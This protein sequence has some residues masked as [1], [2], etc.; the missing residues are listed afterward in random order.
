METAD[1]ESSK[2][3]TI[4]RIAAPHFVAGAELGLNNRIKRLIQ[5]WFHAAFWCDSDAM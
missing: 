5:K 2:R 1:S 3:K 4:I